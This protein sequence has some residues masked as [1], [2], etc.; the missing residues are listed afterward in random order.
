MVGGVRVG[1]Y[2]YINP[3]SFLILLGAWLGPGDE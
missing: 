2:R 1:Y 3:L